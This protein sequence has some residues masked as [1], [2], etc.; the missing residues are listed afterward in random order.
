MF[1]LRGRL[2]ILQVYFKLYKDDFSDYEN[3]EDFDVYSYCELF[4]LSS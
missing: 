4:F 3:T 2:G 1:I